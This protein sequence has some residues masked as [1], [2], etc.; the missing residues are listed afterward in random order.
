MRLRLLCACIMYAAQ[1][2]SATDPD[3]LDA[4]AWRQDQLAALRGDGEGEGEGGAS[5][6][7]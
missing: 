6:G 1:P 4:I 5:G 3:L 2:N 7:T